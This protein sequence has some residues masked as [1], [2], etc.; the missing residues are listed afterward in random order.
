MLHA[1][2]SEFESEL[3]FAAPHQLCRPLCTPEAGQLAELPGP[4][5]QVFR[6]FRK[7]GISSRRQLRHHLALA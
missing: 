5:R 1:S 7:L 6:I 4:H 3:P 2:G